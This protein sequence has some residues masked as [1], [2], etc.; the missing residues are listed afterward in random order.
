MTE[1]KISWLALS[2]IP[3]LGSSRFFAL[4]SVFPSASAV[5][6]AP[7]S[8]L[9]P[10]VGDTVAH[11]I[12]SGCDPTLLQRTLTWSKEEGN[13]ILCHFEENYPDQLK[14]IF[15]P[16]AVLYVIGHDLSLLQST[17]LAMVGSRHP[18]PTGKTTAF[19]FAQSL[20]HS[21]LTI[22]SGLASGIDTQAHLGALDGIGSTIAVMGTGADLVYPAS[23][24]TLAATIANK[25]L[26]ITEFP[27]G[28]GPLGQNFPRRNR[29]ISALSFGC[30]VVEAALLSGSLITSR[31]ALEQGKEVFAIPGSIH[32]PQSKG[33]HQLIKQG[34]KLV[35]SIADILEEVR[36]FIPTSE[37]NVPEDSPSSAKIISENISQESDLKPSHVAKTN[38]IKNEAPTS[39]KKQ[40][41]S[42]KTLLTKESHLANTANTP[43]MQN[44]FA[45]PEPDAMANESPPPPPL[46]QKSS[47]KQLTN[48]VIHAEVLAAIGQEQ[49]NINQLSEK[50]HIDI[51]NL[52][53]K[54][55]E[56]EMHGLV[57]K[58]LSGQYI[59]TIK[60]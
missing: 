15:Y 43:S 23:N 39:P 25:G 11:A 8:A 58:L 42:V 3:G 34:A 60:G 14:E 17:S 4:L 37:Q 26:L 7:F 35:D 38:P 50:L 55:L 30:L 16:P 49:I 28:V 27:L 32:H 29:I 19:Q 54:L 5:L 46:K 24:K 41:K 12:C 47:K 1:E 56:L 20:S 52:Q 45:Q 31:Y 21:G 10:L 53:V 22:V 48:P 36:L 51:Q 40:R 2:L 18:T 44:I 57:K 6:N 33:C 9:S 13:H 59:C